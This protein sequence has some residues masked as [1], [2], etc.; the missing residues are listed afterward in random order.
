MQSEL[1][2]FY[3][4]VEKEKVKVV[5]TP[6]FEPYVMSKYKT[7]AEEFYAKFSLDATLKTICYSC[8]DV[9]IGANDPIVI[10]A[11][12]NAIRNNAITPRVQLIVR[13]SPAEDD[14]RFTVIRAEFP[15]I[16]WNVPKW[17]LTRENHVES[18]SQRIPSEEDIIDLRSLMENVDLNVNMC[19]TMS[20]DFML[21]DR[22]VINTVFG[23]PENRLYDDQRFLNYDHYK[24]VID[25]N[26]PNFTSKIGSQTTK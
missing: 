7:T 11:I 21:F 19:S 24:K 4:R 20:L 26:D 23:N 15:E 13:T 16:V 5:G 18:W 25:C 22:P 14:S 3:P 6:Q 10:R 1:L 8:A 17:V 12:A 2:F 9:S